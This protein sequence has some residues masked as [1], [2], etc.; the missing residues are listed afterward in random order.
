M[1]RTTTRFTDNN[2][3]SYGYYGQTLEPT[4]EPIRDPL[5]RPT[6]V[7]QSNHWMNF[8]GNYPTAC[9][10]IKNDSEISS[11]IGETWT[12]TRRHVY[13]GSVNSSDLMLYPTQKEVFQVK[14]NVCEKIEMIKRQLDVLVEENILT[15]ESRAGEITITM[16]ETI[17]L[18]FAVCDDTGIF[19]VLIG[20]PAIVIRGQPPNDMFN[21]NKLI[22]V[23]RSIFDRNESPLCSNLDFEIDEDDW[24]DLQRVT[25]EPTE[26]FFPRKTLS[27]I[28]P[29]LIEEFD[30]EWSKDFD[31]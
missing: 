10:E 29:D 13:I 12:G 26:K 17:F 22:F 18:N 25:I 31:F 27:L 7:R 1:E 20:K 11:L 3:P 9:A 8:F 23:I 19:H 21:L 4:L 2:S 16:G 14:K 15:Y 28:N 6:L 24:H 30:L 5:V